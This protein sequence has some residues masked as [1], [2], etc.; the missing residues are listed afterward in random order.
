MP[1]STTCDGWPDRQHIAILQGMC[2]PV[3]GFD[4]FA[5]DQ[6]QVHQLGRQAKGLDHL[7][8][9]RTMATGKDISLA[10]RTEP[11]K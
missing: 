5:I 2:G 11:G 6:H 9:G 8:D 4:V 7:G 3:S 10:G 1:D